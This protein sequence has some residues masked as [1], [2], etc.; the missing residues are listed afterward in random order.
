MVAISGDSVTAI[1]QVSTSIDLCLSSSEVCLVV[2]LCPRRLPHHQWQ[3]PQH[4]QGFWGEWEVADCR[5]YFGQN[6]IL[7]WQRWSATA[8]WWQGRLS[9]WTRRGW[10]ATAQSSQ[11]DISPTWMRALWA[12]WRAGAWRGTPRRWWGKWLPPGS[13]TL[14]RSVRDDLPRF[15]L[16]GGDWVACWLAD[17]GPGVANQ[18]GGEEGFPW[19][20]QPKDG[21]EEGRHHEWAQG[22][23]TTKR[24]NVSFWPTQILDAISLFNYMMR[25]IGGPRD[26]SFFFQGVWT[27]V[28]PIGW[29]L[30]KWSQK[31]VCTNL[32]MCCYTR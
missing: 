13:W 16:L 24:P 2:C 15:P 7:Y 21:G 10:F 29:S 8:G 31:L 20:R 22:Q 17:W 11:G 19:P 32:N 18:P 27:H 6:L 5:R 12:D 25:D 4:R 1:R 30:Q 26:F 9:C 28:Y 3:E 23:I 14:P